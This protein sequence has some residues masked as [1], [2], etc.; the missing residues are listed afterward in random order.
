M[1]GIVQ[2]NTFHLHRV[3]VA[4]NVAIEAG[5]T[6]VQAQHLFVRKTEVVSPEQV[7]CL[8]R[9]A[10]TRPRVISQPLQVAILEEEDEVVT[11]VERSVFVVVRAEHALC[12]HA[13]QVHRDAEALLASSPIRVTDALEGGQAILV[14]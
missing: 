12:G 9:A 3:G 10:Q 14:R 4:V 8:Y 5:S 6:K 2:R 11:F 13:R 7:N 1:A